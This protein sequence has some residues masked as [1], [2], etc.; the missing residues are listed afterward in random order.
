M[1]STQSG[2]A[3]A[4]T[5]RLW[6]ADRVERW[7]IGRLIP[8]ASNPRL[9]S[10][11]DLDKLDASIRKW[12]WTMPVPVDEEGELI[13]GALR[14]R[15]AI[16]LGLTEVPV[17]V[18]HGWSEGEKRAY[19]VAD[20]QLAARASWDPEQLYNELEALKFSEFDLDLIGFEPDQLAT[21]LSGLR[22]SGLADPDSVPELPD[23]SVSRRGDVW[24][25]GGHRIGCGDSTSA[26][27]V[28]A[29]LAGSEPHVMV[30][31]PPY[32]VSYEPSWRSRR[33][34]GAGKL[35]RGKVL[36]DDRADWREAY[37]LFRGDVCYVWHGALHGDVVAAD[38]AACG[39]ALRLS[40]PSST[41]RWAVAIIIGGTK[42][43]GTPCGRA[44]PATGTAAARRRRSGRSPT[45]IL[46]ATRSASRVGDMA[47]RSRSNACAAQSSTTAG[48][49]RRSMIRFS[50]RARV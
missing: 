33:G 3:E 43:V 44:N 8:Y 18:T 47:R 37:A 23:Q 7:P 42:P 45:T 21:I 27:D 34:V 12:G 49:A 1:S 30:T 46:S 25:L 35:A 38:L 19:R 29:V 32:G 36:N 26:A 50:V 10:E 17:I 31:D 15:A 28:T 2:P 14:L 48:S 5:A 22:P 16:R 4:S 11:A 24:L 40:G 41:S 13:A 20:N 6:P 39:C 9:H